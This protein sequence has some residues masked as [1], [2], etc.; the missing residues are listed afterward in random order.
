MLVHGLGG[1]IHDGEFNK[2]AEYVLVL[3]DRAKPS[4]RRGVGLR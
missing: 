2:M 4:D 1:S 3:G